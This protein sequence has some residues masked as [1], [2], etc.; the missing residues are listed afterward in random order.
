[1]I[2]I[3]RAQHLRDFIIT[4]DFSDGSQ[5]DYDLVPLLER[6]TVLT[7][8]LQDRAFF[9]RFFIELGALAWPNGLELSAES[10]HRRL[11]EQ[12]KLRR[13]ERVA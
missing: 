1:V 3:L 10:T 5:G 8:A 9:R 4:L 12:G 11:E 6:D 13:S 7:R 2:K